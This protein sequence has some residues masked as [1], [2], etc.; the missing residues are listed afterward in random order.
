[1]AVNS[2]IVRDVQ[3]GVTANGPQK[4]ADTNTPSVEYC[5]V[6]II[7]SPND[8]SQTYAQADNAQVLT[9]GAAIAAQAKDGRTYTPIPSGLAFAGLGDEGASTGNAGAK[10]LAMSSTT[11]TFEVTTGA[12]GAATEHANAALGA[13]ATGI[14][15]FVAYT[16]L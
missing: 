9:L 5:I 11:M 7:P 16:V 2:F 13:Y 12:V 15:V 10:T 8:G 3:F 1:M 4:S 14:K 6:D